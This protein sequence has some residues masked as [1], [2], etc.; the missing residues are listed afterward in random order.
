MNSRE[1]VSRFKT[2]TTE[3]VT[4]ELTGEQMEVF[5]KALGAPD[6]KRRGLLNMADRVIVEVAGFGGPLEHGYVRPT[7]G[8]RMTLSLRVMRWEPPKRKTRAPAR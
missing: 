7:K 6:P 2:R 5:G 3:I 8:E 1:V 4:L